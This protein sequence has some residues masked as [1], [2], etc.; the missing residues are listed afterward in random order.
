MGPPLGLGISGPDPPYAQSPFIL[1]D[2]LNGFPFLDFQSLSQGGGTNQIELA[3]PLGPF[4]HLNFRYVSHGR[5][6]LSRML[7][8][9]Y[10]SYMAM[11]IFFYP[12]HNFFT[13]PLPPR[14]GEIFAD[15]SDK[16]RDK[17][18]DSIV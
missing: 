2:P 4:D 1:D 5:R 3:L 12:F 14:G 15:I 18:S 16:V 10:H 13:P 6:L 11:S 9:G 8:G 17:F 7:K